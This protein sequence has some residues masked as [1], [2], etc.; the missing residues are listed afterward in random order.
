MICGRKEEVW[1]VLGHAQLSLYATSWVAC[2]DSGGVSIK[3]AVAIQTVMLVSSLCTGSTQPYWFQS[4]SASFILISQVEGVS[5][6]PQVVSF[7]D[8]PASSKIC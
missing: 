7:I 8:Y 6:F 3:H 1:E 5:V 4:I 2:A